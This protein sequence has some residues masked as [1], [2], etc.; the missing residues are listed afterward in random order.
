MFEKW[1]IKEHMEVT[2][3]AGRHVGT[4][5]S[6]DGDT[7]KLTRSD[8]TD[9]QHHLLDFDAVDKIEDNRVYLKS[10]TPLPQGFEATDT[11]PE[12]FEQAT[13]RVTDTEIAGAE[14]NIDPGG[15]A[16]LFGTSGH[17]TGM[18]GSGTS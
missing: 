2:D 13:G 17:G 8:S 4:I 15:D 11:R 1:R 5:D 16:P 9:G 6:V 7:I 3:A 10:G 18:G 12:Q 14:S